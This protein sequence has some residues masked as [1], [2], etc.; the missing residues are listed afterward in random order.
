MI[1]PLL[2]ILTKLYVESDGVTHQSEETDIDLPL[3][4]GLRRTTKTLCKMCGCVFALYIPMSLPKSTYFVCH[5]CSNVLYNEAR[6]M[7]ISL[8]YKTMYR[9]SVLPRI[10]LDIQAIGMLPN[11]ITQSRLFDC[12]WNL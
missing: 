7:Y 12:N 2:D 4:I 9:F 10:L 6:K 1:S 3:S 5:I 11:R 8:K